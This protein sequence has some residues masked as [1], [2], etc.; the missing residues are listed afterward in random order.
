MV[1]QKIVVVLTDDNKNEFEKMSEKMSE[2][3]NERIREKM[4]ERLKT[5][6]Q[7]QEHLK[8]GQKSRLQRNHQLRAEYLE[9]RR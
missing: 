2:K 4:S 7:G 6:Q 9:A 1:C 5:Y 3:M 8:L